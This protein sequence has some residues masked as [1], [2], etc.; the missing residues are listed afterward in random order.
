MRSAE[1]R[2]AFAGPVVSPTTDHRLLTTGW[3]L[4]KPNSGLKRC[5]QTICGCVRPFVFTVAGR[6]TAGN[7]DTVYRLCTRT[8][9][10]KER[11]DA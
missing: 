1:T 2:A 8:A 7:P 3:G 5:E 9:P 4:S 11:S 6:T 10:F